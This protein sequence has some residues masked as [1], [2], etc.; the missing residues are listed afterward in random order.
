[1][2]EKVGEI[3]YQLTEQEYKEMR[4]LLNDIKEYFEG[5]ND[6]RDAKF[7]VNRLLKIIK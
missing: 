5:E 6:F 3:R 1:M 4:N 2:M 7:S